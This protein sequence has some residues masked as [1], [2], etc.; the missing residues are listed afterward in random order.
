[1]P[2]TDNA[3]SYFFNFLFQRKN[4]NKMNLF[5]KKSLNR[6]SRI[7]VSRGVNGR[8]LAL[9]IRVDNDCMSI[10][11]EWV[12]AVNETD[13]L[14]GSW[15]Q[16]HISLKG[17]TRRFFPIIAAARVTDNS[18]I[19]EKIAIR[20][21]RRLLNRRERMDLMGKVDIARHNRKIRIVATIQRNRHRTEAWSSL[22]NTT[23]SI[24][25]SKTRDDHFQ[26]L[27]SRNVTQRRPKIMDL[28]STSDFNFFDRE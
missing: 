24:R 2:L 8:Q 11:I 17:Q 5:R 7:K 10:V 4:I 13:R 18:L 14:T 12:R 3:N 16:T 23:K 22:S 20:P 1:M 21:A 26:F 9:P 28:P 25:I 27:I 6:Q 19:I 15:R